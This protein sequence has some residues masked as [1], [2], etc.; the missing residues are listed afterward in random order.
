MFFLISDDQRPHPFRRGSAGI[1]PYYTPYYYNVIQWDL[2]MILI[3]ASGKRAFSSR[4]MG[5]S[6]ANSYGEFLKLFNYGH[7]QVR[8]L[9]VIPRG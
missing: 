1:R 8:K 4:T 9:L 2:V 6:M 5:T 7:F 3:I